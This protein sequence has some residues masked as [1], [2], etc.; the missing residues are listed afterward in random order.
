MI[1]EIFHNYFDE[2]I[3]LPT[4][5]PC[6]EISR[7][8]LDKERRDSAS[9]QGVPASKALFLAMNIYCIKNKYHGMYAVAS[10]GMYAIF[11]M[12]TG[13]LKLFNAVFLKKGRLFTIFICLP[14]SALLKTLLAKIN[15]VT[16][17]AK[18]WSI[19]AI[20]TSG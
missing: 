14:A 11:A 18:C 17:F 15:P 8:F 3:I 5:V 4:D 16:G 19:Y 10:R 20:I 6:C 1:S 13:K 12:Q 9:L 7:L 2:T